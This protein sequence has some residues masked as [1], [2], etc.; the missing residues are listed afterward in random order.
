MLNCMRC[1]SARKMRHRGRRLKFAGDTS[2]NFVN[3]RMDNG[4]FNVYSSQEEME[5]ARLKEA[6]KKTYTERFHTLMRLIKISAMLSKAK[7]IYPAK[8]N[9]S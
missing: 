5:L 6:A 4:R 2:R 7:V 8:T 3:L 9:E 1:S